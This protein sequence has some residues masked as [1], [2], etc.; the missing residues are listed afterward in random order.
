MRKHL[1]TA[2]LNE[3]EDR[4]LALLCLELCQW[5]WA[6]AGEELSLSAVCLPGVRGD[7][8]RCHPS[9]VGKTH[10]FR[11]GTLQST[12]EAGTAEFRRVRGAG[13]T[14]NPG[15]LTIGA[16]G[17]S[18]KAQTQHPGGFRF[19]C[20]NSFFRKPIYLK[21]NLSNDHLI[22]FTNYQ[23]LVLRKSLPGYIQLFYSSCILFLF[24]FT[25]A[26]F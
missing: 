17:L 23:K 6:G 21:V 25:S 8:Q 16:G 7:G 26:V 14:Q 20:Q 18:M 4:P 24:F 5:G 3:K 1:Q 22:K 2:R 11:S 13:N 9:H 19:L 12:P 15:R 10:C